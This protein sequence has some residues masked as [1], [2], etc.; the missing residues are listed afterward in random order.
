[1]TVVR[2][3]FAAS[4]AILGLVGPPAQ[5]GLIDI[6]GSDTM[7]ILNQE[8]ATTYAARHAGIDFRVSGGGSN[9]GIGELLEG[10]TDIAASSRALSSQE[11]KSFERDFGRAPL[12]IAIGLDGIG[13]YVHNN[14]PVARLT[15]EQLRGI[16]AGEINNWKEVGGGDRPIAV[17][18]RDAHSGTHHYFKEHVLQGRPFA[19]GTR[20]VATTGTLSAMVARNPSAIGYGGIGYSLGAHVIEVAEKERVESIFPSVETVESGT[21][22]LSRRLYFYIDPARYSPEIRRFVSWVL[23]EPGQEVVALVGYYRLR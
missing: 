12:E 23:S 14:N 16:F 4:A 20:F 22:P 11:M 6:K 15:I 13:V 19:A 18:S 21:Y 1:M 10:R 8:L 2:C 3:I 17:V 9:V 5:A 7:V